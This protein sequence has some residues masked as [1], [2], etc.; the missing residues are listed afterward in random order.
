MLKT[1]AN[2]EPSQHWRHMSKL[3]RGTLRSLSNLG[4]TGT[5]TTGSRMNVSAQARPKHF[6]VV[7]ASTTSER[8]VSRRRERGKKLELNWAL[9]GTNLLP[10]AKFDNWLEF[11]LSCAVVLSSYVRV[12]YHKRLIL[13]FPFLHRWRQVWKLERKQTRKQFIDGI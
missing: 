8:V 1:L 7:P 11:L 2:W 5:T 10:F 6:V 9:K 12:N 3:C 4:T 13:S